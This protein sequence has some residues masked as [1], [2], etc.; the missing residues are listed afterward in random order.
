MPPINAFRW[1]AIGLPAYLRS[2]WNQFDIAITLL[3]IV[4][5]LLEH[6]HSQGPSSPRFI[7]ALRLL[8]V[9]RLFRLVRRAKGMR[10]LLN[11]LYWWV[12]GC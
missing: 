11:T 7:P 6:L 1:T 10:K 2:G 4:A 8:R 5:V 12:A 3:S 9:A